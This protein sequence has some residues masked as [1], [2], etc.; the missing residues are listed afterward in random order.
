MW[1]RERMI[2]T[3]I[4][5]AAVLIGAAVLLYTFLTVSIADRKI[6]QKTERAARDLLHAEAAIDAYRVD[7]GEAFQP[8]NEDALPDA[9]AEFFAGRRGGSPFHHEQA[10]VARLDL[11]SPGRPY[12]Q[13]LAFYRWSEK[14]VLVSRGPDGRLDI[15]PAL[16][17]S[18]GEDNA[19]GLAHRLA[20]FTYDPTNGSSSA[21]DLW[22][23]GPVR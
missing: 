3:S 17:H 7:T 12:S 23:S 15:E 22:V 19:V 20:P 2:R 21:G 5:L 4:M 18:H 10:R 14:W 6:S 11:F 8:T 9:F 13:P 16:G 1:D